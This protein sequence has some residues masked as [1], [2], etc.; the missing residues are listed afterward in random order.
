[1]FLGAID[2]QLTFK[3][4]INEWYL[5]FYNE[6]Y[7]YSSMLQLLMIMLYI[8]VCGIYPEIGTRVLGLG[9]ESDSSPDLAGL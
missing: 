4:L 5:D 2:L 8:N 9:L 3:Y 1:M 6:F 7:I